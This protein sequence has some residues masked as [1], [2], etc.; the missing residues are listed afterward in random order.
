MDQITALRTESFPI[1]VLS[2]LTG[3]HIETIRY[4]E[5]IGMLP[6]PPRTA[7]GRRIYSPLHVQ[8]LSFIRRGRELGFTIEK[9]RALLDLGGP[10][11]APCG[12]VREIA[13]NHLEEVR[14]KIADLKKLERLLGERIG[15]C[16]GGRGPDCPV[17]QTLSAG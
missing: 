14:T 13:A 11:M 10:S 12:A 6:A 16:D 8:T 2:R 4:Y 3:V 7:G 17:L 9:I 15:R 1:G 5:R